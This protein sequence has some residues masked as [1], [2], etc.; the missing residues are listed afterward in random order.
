MHSRETERHIMNQGG[1]TQGRLRTAR[2]TE[3]KQPS[4]NLHGREGPGYRMQ[5]TH[6]R[7]GQGR[8][9][10]DGPEYAV[11]KLHGGRMFEQVAILGFEGRVDDA[12][13]DPVIAHFGEGVVGASRV[14]P[15]DESA[16]YHSEKGET[17]DAAARG[18]QFHG[19]LNLL[20]G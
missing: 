2:Q 3:T 5:Q 4:T 13:R 17:R 12:G 1:D 6:G 18:A 15:R 10:R 7:Q 14:V 11:R 19:E 16:G 9:G 8:Q 20:P